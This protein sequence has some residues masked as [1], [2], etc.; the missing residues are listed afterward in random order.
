[1]HEVVEISRACFMHLVLQ[2]S[3]HFSQLDLNLANLEAT[4]EAE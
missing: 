4:V 3:L 2:Y 1:M